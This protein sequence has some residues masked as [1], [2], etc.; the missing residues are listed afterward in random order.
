[1]LQDMPLVLSKNYDCGVL[2]K[3]CKREVGV[4]STHPSNSRVLYPSIAGSKC[5]FILNSWY[6][7][8]PK[9]SHLS[10]GMH[11]LNALR[12]LQTEYCSKLN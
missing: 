4:D 11:G 5:Q 1:M 12:G 7:I 6:F 2:S 9:S 10:R 8:L 3:N